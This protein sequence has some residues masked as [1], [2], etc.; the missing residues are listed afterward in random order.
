VPAGDSAYD[1]FDRNTTEQV[2]NAIAENGNTIFADTKD[3]SA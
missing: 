2:L 3:S 1:A